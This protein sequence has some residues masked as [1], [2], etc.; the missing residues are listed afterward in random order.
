[1]TSTLPPQDSADTNAARSRSVLRRIL[2]R[3]KTAME[4]LLSM[5]RRGKSAIDYESLVS[6]SNGSRVSAIKTMSRLSQRL[7]SLSSLSREDLR[8]PPPENKDGDKHQQRSKS[9][10]RRGHTSGSSTSSTGY[11]STE[12]KGPQGSMTERRK[13]KSKKPGVVRKQCKINGGSSAPSPT[14]ETLHTKSPSRV[15]YISMSSD[16]TQ[17]GEIPC[18]SRQPR[19]VRPHDGNYNVS[20]VYPLHAYPPTTKEKRGLLKRIFGASQKARAGDPGNQ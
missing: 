8:S 9:V 20:P 12:S 1:M 14:G 7:N 3:L 16:S 15:S 13:K 18:R 10:L 17:L 19:L 6:L 5:A 11:D 2:E 4:S